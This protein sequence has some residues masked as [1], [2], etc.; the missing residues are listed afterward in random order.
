MTP[1]KSVNLLG[2]FAVAMLLATAGTAMAHE[3]QVPRAANKAHAAQ[4]H[5]RTVERQR[6]ET[7]R[8]RRDT[9]TR[10]D[11]GTATRDAEI[12]RERD[13]GSTTRYVDYTGF[14]GKSRSVDSVR[15]RTEGGF[16]REAN[17]TTLEGREGS[18][19]DVIQ[20]TEEGFTRDT[21]RTAPDG[22]THT[23]TVEVA[24]DKDASKCV[25][26]VEVGQKP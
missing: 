9:L 3:T 15:T 4:P 7:G 17:Y 21:V 19:S 13:T 23:R 1:N 18:M 5:T 20:R 12:N 11:G 6:T 25:K 22:R 16:T 10:A 8:T 24:C 14:D 26:Q 2:T